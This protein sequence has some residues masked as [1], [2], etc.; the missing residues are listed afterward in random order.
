[1]STAKEKLFEELFNWGEV[2]WCEEDNGII[3]IKTEDGWLIIKDDE[4]QNTKTQD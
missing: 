3:K 4:I 2:I 1:M